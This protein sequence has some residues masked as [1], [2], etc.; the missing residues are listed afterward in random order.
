MSPAEPTML[1]RADNKELIKGFDYARDTPDIK[2][3]MV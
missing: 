3:V 2:A 1:E